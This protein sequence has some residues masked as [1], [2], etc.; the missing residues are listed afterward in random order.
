[1]YYPEQRH[2]LAWTTIRRERLLPDG[3]YGIVEARV[4]QHVN[5]RDVVAR[6]SVPARY[7]FLDAAAYFGV[8]SDAA[9]QDLM[10]VEVGETV[11]P[12]QVIAG[13]RP[14]RG[15]RLLSPVV[16][17]VRHVGQ[18]QIILQETPDPIEV[19]AG[20]VGQVVA[21]RENRG[22][23]IE[24]FG[25]LLQGLW[26]NDRRV[27]GP[28]RME[29]QDGLESIVGDG[30]DGLG[31]ERQYSGTV[32][33]TR[34]PLKTITLDALESTQEAQRIGGVIAPTM[35]IDLRERAEQLSTA[36]ILMEGFGETRF[37][38]PLLSML[39]GF[40]GRQVTVD[41]FRPNRWEGRR[42]E[43]FVSLPPRSGEHPP[44]PNVNQ[45][46]QVGT[47]VRIAR[48]PNTGSVGQVTNL[49]KTPQLIDNGLR[50][51]CAEIALVTGEKLMVPLANLEVFGK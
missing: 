46:L 39:E 2:Q 26:G 34:R 28:L 36:I 4:G 20:L 13:K 31:L 43:L 47:P 29:P 38:G 48:E 17:I 1:M 7:V 23:V 21:L 22:V 11:E 44:E 8:K 9:L 6:G 15:R 32:V 45:T 51:R 30:E 40:E 50:V 12:E 18:G 37:S 24:T 33:I 10:L 27:I 42:P 14:D 19:Q 25:A 49:P 5:L 3:A 35:D 41:A 16:G